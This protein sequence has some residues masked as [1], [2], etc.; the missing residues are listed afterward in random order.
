RSRALRVLPATTIHAIRGR[1]RTRTCHILPQK[2]SRK[3]A[4]Q[5]ALAGARNTEGLSPLFANDLRRDRQGEF[6]AS[7]AR[8]LR[9][10]GK[11]SRT[12]YRARLRAGP[13]RL[14][15]LGRGERQSRLFH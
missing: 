4:R 15:L 2:S 11:S 7:P 8:A 3:E 13:S 1:C 6:P 14:L 5:G 9:T 12:N 10:I